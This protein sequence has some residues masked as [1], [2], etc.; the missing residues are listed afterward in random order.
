MPLVTVQSNVLY[1]DMLSFVTSAVGVH[2]S[3]ITV[4]R[5]T[6]GKEAPGTHWIRG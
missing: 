1:I 5:I 2:N 6:I 4:C 3:Q